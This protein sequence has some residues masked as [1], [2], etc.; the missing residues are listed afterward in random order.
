MSEPALLYEKKDGIAFVTMNRPD[1]RNAINTEMLVRLA[2]AWIDAHQVSAPQ[3]RFDVV[4][5]L[6]SPRGA[7]Q[8]EHVRGLG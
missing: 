6:R 3:V 7:A 5:V 8:V 1:V 4:A 2:D